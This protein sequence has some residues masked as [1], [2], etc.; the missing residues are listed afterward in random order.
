MRFAL[1]PL[2][3][4]AMLLNVA[5][6]LLPTALYAPITATL[7]RATMSPYSI[8]VAPA[9]SLS[10]LFSTDDN[11]NSSTI[12]R[13][14]EKLR[15]GSDALGMRGIRPGRLSEEPSALAATWNIVV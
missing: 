1:Q 3:G 9:S 13:A 12:C 6:K 10:N 5:V 2:K 8:A 7:I 15:A 14:T 11:R 4:I